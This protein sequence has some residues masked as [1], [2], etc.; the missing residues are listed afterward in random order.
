MALQ[1]LYN[2]PFGFSSLFDDV[3]EPNYHQL[4]R[5]PPSSFSSLQIQEDDK[6]YSIALDVPGVKPEDMK[7]QLKDNDRVLH[8]SG[9]RKF[10]KEG[11]ESETRFDRRFTIGENVDIENIRADLANGVLTITAPKKSPEELAP[12]DIPITA[13]FDASV[14]TK[15]WRNRAL[16]NS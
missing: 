5:H 11:T 15:K 3:F 7:M 12:R 9:G 6:A 8:L 2:D 14:I 4:M 1:S 16:L 10:Q 13:S